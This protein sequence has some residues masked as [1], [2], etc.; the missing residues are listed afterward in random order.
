LI[1][2]NPTGNNFALSGETVPLDGCWV[3]QRYSDYY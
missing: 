3:L 1:N 2:Q